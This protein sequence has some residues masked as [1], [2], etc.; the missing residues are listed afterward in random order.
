MGGKSPSLILGPGAGKTVLP[1][2][3]FQIMLYFG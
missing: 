1:S 3:K 2:R